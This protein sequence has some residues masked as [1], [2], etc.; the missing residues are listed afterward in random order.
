MEANSCLVLL[1]DNE[2]APTDAGR[3][4]SAGTSMTRREV[5]LLIVNDDDGGDGDAGRLGGRRDGNDF[6][7]IIMFLLYEGLCGTVASERVLTPMYQ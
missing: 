2:V 3:R 7:I 5:F 6:G 1:L 4:L